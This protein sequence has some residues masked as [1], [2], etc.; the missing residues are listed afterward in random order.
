MQFFYLFELFIKEKKIST[1]PGELSFFGEE[2][3]WAKTKKAQRP[4]PQ[5][6]YT[7]RSRPVI[8]GGTVMPSMPSIVGA[9]SMSEPSERRPTPRSPVPSK[10]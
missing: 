8:S 7:L 6:F 3:L 2:E 10:I 4:K 9:T 1:K 5:L